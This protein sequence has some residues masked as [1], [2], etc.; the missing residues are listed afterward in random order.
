MPWRKGTFKDQ[1][2]WIEVDGDGRPN[3]SGGRVPIRYQ[4]HDGA[5]I[6][7]AGAG[8]VTI[9][10]SAPLESLSAGTEAPDRSE[11]SGSKSSRG[12]GFGKAG[13]RTAA[14]AALAAD[15]ARQQ[16]D[17]LSASAVIAFSDGACRG[18]P[19]PA[20]SGAYV[21]LPNGDRWAGSRHL[22]RATNNVAELTAIALVL[23]ILRDA[24]VALHTHVAIFSDSSYANGVLVKGWKAK[25][26]QELIADLR[27]RLGKWP[28]LEIIW[29]A[30]HAGVEGNERADALANEGVDGID[31]LRKL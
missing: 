24:K 14:Q 31:G 27:A 7:R 10:D 13:T 6:Y 3:E 1:T 26:N 4:A 21:E 30:G 16:I 20:G 9:D 22:G 23:D 5:K 19:G 8:R 17:A 12:S 29:V 11:K 25:A 28:K 2:V 15:A 18:N